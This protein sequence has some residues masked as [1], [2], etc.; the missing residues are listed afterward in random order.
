MDC[1]GIL[2]GSTQYDCS[3]DPSLDPTDPINVAACG[4]AARYDC[5]YGDDGYEQSEDA[6][7]G[8]CEGTYEYQAWR[9]DAPL[10]FIDEGYSEECYTYN[11]NG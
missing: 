9:I 7:R 3:Y 4:G 1:L 5:R 8:Y 10:A 2:N 11:N 6:V